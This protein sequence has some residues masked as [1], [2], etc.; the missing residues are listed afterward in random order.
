MTCVTVRAGIGLLALLW[1]VT[2]GA[3]ATLYD[4]LGGP[5]AV[6]V[7]AATLIDR[8]AGDPRLGR[9]FKGANLSRIKKLLAEQLCEL[10]DGGCHYSGDSMRETHAGHHITESEFYG[11][12]D[13]LRTILR[14]RSV[15]L[16]ETNELLGLLAPMKRDVVEGPAGKKTP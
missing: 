3:R 5:A 6:T 7:I 12:V 10:T 11:M 9:S 13:T 14:E 8:V 15:G 1:A 2:A 16:A 4:R